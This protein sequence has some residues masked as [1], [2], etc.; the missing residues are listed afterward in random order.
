[1]LKVALGAALAKQSF[2]NI[3]MWIV[4]TDCMTL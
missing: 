3:G 1:M 4:I 2:T